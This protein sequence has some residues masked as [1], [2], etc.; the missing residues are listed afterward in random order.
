[1]HLAGASELKSSSVLAWRLRRHGLHPRL[2]TGDPA[3]VAERVCGLHAQVM[4][5]ADLSLLARLDDHQP[6]A[7]ATALWRDRTLV[8]LWAARGTLHLLPAASLPTWL[9]ALST[10]RKFGNNGH[11]DTQRIC[12]AVATALHDRILTRPE[13]AEEV[14]RLTGSPRL[15]SWV[16]SSWGSDLKAA[17][18]R[19]LLCFAENGFT[20]PEH[21]LG[22]IDRSGSSSDSLRSV[23]R[24]FLRSYAPTTPAQIARWWAGPPRERLGR[25]LLDLIRPET[26]LV[27]HAGH[28][29][30]VL[31]ADL[32]E[33]RAT[34]G[35][36]P[37]HASAGLPPPHASAGLPAP[38]TSAGLPTPHAAVDPPTLRAAV[39]VPGIRA[40][41]DHSEA[42]AVESASYR[43]LPAF[44][45]WVLGMPREE[46]FIDP[47]HLPAVFRPAGRIA[48]VILTN[49]RITGTWTH[50][51]TPR[52]AEI[53][54]TPFDPPATRQPLTDEAERIA[55]HLGRPLSISWAW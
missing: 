44:D 51:V 21:W 23:V 45:P 29:A 1:M 55:T 4:S 28:D 6:G 32:P 34:A 30:L 39:D 15:A 37:P 43:L 12:D 20:S 35:L 19:G 26:E 49:G 2:P 46:P 33:L 36:P 17:S 48:P 41:D 25:E 53:T 18:F 5:S 27:H 38:R 10:L 54:L 31:A 22:P 11:P 47:K 8:K 14:G 42:H 7:L 40:A 50:R 13:L 52:H 3:A 16:L 24:L 9:G